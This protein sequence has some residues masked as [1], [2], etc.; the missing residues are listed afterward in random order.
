[1]GHKLVKPHKDERIEQALGTPD[2]YCKH[3]RERARREGGVEE[4]QELR[5]PQRRRRTA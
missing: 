4:E 5:R 1:M 2:A 3:A